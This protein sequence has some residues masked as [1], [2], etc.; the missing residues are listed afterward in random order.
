MDE[1][2]RI[3]RMSRISKDVKVYKRQFSTITM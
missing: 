1:Q 2:D 3:I